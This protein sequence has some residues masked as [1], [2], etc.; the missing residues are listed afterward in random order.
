MINPREWLT[1][2]RLLAAQ[3]KLIVAQTTVIDWQAAELNRIR[4]AH[5]REING[6]VDAWLVHHDQPEI[7][8]RPGLLAFSTDLADRIAAIEELIL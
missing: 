8:M 1:P 3:Q 2:W 6:L 7:D 5:F 4:L